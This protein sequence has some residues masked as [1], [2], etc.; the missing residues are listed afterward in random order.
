MYGYHSIGISTSENSA[1][2]ASRAR[3]TPGKVVLCEQV[4]RSDAS[5]EEHAPSVPHLQSCET[6]SIRNQIGT[7]MQYLTVNGAL[8]S[9]VPQHVDSTSAAYSHGMTCLQEQAASQRR[10]HKS[11]Q[12]RQLSPPHQPGKKDLPNSPTV[13]THLKHQSTQH[14]TTRA[15]PLELKA[16]KPLTN[17]TPHAKFSDPKRSAPLIRASARSEPDILPKCTSVNFQTRLFHVAL[18]EKVAF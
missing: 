10:L 8:S 5:L 16:H 12:T 15:P 2:L 11:K 1:R 14:A 3:P 7:P 18:P 4:H 6:R 17:T 13:Q 9:G